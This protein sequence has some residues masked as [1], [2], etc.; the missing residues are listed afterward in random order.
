MANEQFGLQAGPGN[1]ARTLHGLAACAADPALLDEGIGPSVG[2]V[3]RSWA[4][5]TP[6]VSISFE[7]RQGAR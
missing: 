2:A 7:R 1:Q 5:G 4:V 6:A 3:T